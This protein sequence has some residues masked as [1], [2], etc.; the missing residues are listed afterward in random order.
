VSI[1]SDI[2]S[3]ATKICTAQIAQM[4][5]GKVDKWMDRLMEGWKDGWSESL[6][7]QMDG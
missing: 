4:L 3:T 6:D 7:R 5:R 2:R 1:L